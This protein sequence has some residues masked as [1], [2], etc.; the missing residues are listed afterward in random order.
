MID[1]AV[2]VSRDRSDWEWKQRLLGSAIS[3]LSSF[4]PDEFSGVYPRDVKSNLPEELHEYVD[5]HTG[6]Q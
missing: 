4:M 1:C 3:S 5:K 2:I 6:K